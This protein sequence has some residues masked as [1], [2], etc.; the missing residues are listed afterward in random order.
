[1]ISVKSFIKT[2]PKTFWIALISLLV[3]QF[4][5]LYSIGQPIISKTGQILLWTNDVVSN[6]NS[7]QIADWY[8][9]SHIIHGFIFFWLLFFVFK[10][11]P[12]WVLALFAVIIEGVWEILENS[13]FIIDRYRETTIAVGYYGDSILNSICDNLWMLLGFFVASKLGW[14]KTLT[15]LII[16]ELLTLMVIRDNL[17]LN[18]IMLLMPIDFIKLWQQGVYNLGFLGI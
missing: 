15:I 12:L 2:A 9:P 5:I 3:L 13:P 6:E 10:K 18:V 1:M 17:T 11:K 8:T 4:L 14:K 16:F 7:Q